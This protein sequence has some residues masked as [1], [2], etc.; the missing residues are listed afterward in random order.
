MLRFTG[1]RAL[2]GALKQTG[3]DIEVMGE[4][5]MAEGVVRIAVSEAAAE[6]SAELFVASDA[7]AAKA[8]AE[9]DT[10]QQAGALARAA[11]ASGVAEIAEGSMAMGA[12]AATEAM[13]E[14]LEERAA[15]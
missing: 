13:G 8:V 9:L 11:V 15:S 14:T 6:R 7:L 4:Q 12:G 1:T 2:A 3:K 10:A 5:E